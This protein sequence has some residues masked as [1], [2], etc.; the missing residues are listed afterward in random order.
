L[1]NAREPLSSVLKSLFALVTSARPQK[2]AL[3]CAE[4]AVGGR[5]PV[6]GLPKQL[7]RC[8]WPRAYVLKGTFETLSMS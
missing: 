7:V 2:Y 1:G 6:R 5:P 3:T 4:S 8:R